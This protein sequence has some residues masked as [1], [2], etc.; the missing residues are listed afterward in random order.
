MTEAGVTISLEVGEAT[1][2]APKLPETQAATTRSKNFVRMNQGDVV[3]LKEVETYHFLMAGD[4]GV[5]V[6][7]FI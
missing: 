2:N 3:H 4:E 1:P 6:T 7:E 5:I